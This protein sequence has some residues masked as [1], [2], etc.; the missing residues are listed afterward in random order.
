MTFLALFNL[1]SEVLAAAPGA[2]ATVEEALTAL[3][4]DGSNAHKTQAVVEAAAQL[5]KTGTQLLNPAA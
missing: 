1:L 5:A 3:H 4:G 2:A